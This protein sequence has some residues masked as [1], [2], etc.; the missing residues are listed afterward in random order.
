M[1]RFATETE[2]LE[3]L[4]LDSPFE[5]RLHAGLYLRVDKSLLVL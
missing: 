5:C 1:K 2:R 3:D 4:R